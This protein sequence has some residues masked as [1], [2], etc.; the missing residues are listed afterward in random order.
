MASSWL[1]TPSVGLL[2]VA[3]ALAGCA[4]GKDG[5]TGPPGSN[6]INASQVSDDF[7]ATL[8]V[9]SEVTGVTISSPPRVTF[10]LETD[11]GIPITGIVP[12]WDQEH[13]Y[14]RFTL[15]KLV[16]G[17][18]GDP[19]S[20]VSYIRDGTTGE[21]D[22]D[23]GSKLVDHL[24]GSYTFTF[25]TDVTAVPGVSYQSG[26]THRLGGQLGSSSISLEPQN[27]V[28]DFRPQ[29][30]G[31]SRTRNIAVMTSCNECHDNL[32]F[33]GRRFEVEYCVTCHNPDLADGEGD[34]SFMIHRIHAAGDFDV[35]EGGIS[36]AEVTYPQDLENCLKCHN[37]MD[38][39][40]PDAGNW[41]D[42]PNMTACDGCHDVFAT[43]THSGGAQSNNS[44]CTTCHSTASIV[45]AHTTPNATPN[46]P[47]LLPD[48][49]E[50]VY[51]LIDASVGG[52]S[53]VTVNLRILADGAPLNVANLPLSLATPDRYPGLLLAWAQR[54]DGIDEPMD[55]N[56]L[57]QRAAQPLSIGLDDFLAGG[58]AGTHAFDAG[59]GV[60][61][62]VVTDEEL[63]FPLDATLRAV[64]LQGYLQQDISGE[65][66]S[67]HTPSAV[68]AV[69]GDDERRHVVDSAKC[70]N[71]HE[72]F[73]GHG[74]NRTYNIQICTLCHVPNLSSS[75]RTVVDPLLRDLDEDLQA[76]LD[77]GTLDPSV[78]PLDPLTY[79]EDA[80]SLKDLVHG[81]HASGQ[82]D[83]PFQFVRGPNRQGYY[84]WSE[85]TFP[86]GASTSDCQLCHLDGSYDLPLMHGLLATTVRTTGVPDG[87]DPSVP[88]VEDAFVAVPNPTDWINTPTASSCFDCH[89]SLEAMAHMEQ[90]GALLSVPSVPIGTYWSNR[91][92]LGTT[93]ESCSVCHGPGKVA[94][95]DAVHNK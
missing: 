60:N 32:V 15:T 66:V 38:L 39:A 45:E 47:N 94:D 6:V 48:Q 73:E 24:D 3:L 40:T 29:G 72:W 46:N 89:T 49:L 20:W 13:R 74:G 82:R 79:P 80:Q 19:D 52:D 18:D 50:I 16:P 77:A 61:T 53:D 31:V 5:A 83:R 91:S 9:V 56:N 63:Q 30:G 68:A 64:G 69:T 33:H 11:T 12:F 36:Y 78:D 86:R 27:F 84:D 4:D 37:P 76:A 51:E 75:G 41:M 22:Y 58:T 57:G 7:L 59:T 35:L 67:L 43:G 44:M 93:F 25:S 2:A 90:N 42:L 14:V 1:K 92:D 70:S 10:T 55:Y 54:Q 71:C 34:M 65:I 21:P 85:V 28:H 95:L 87:S 26:L 62:F 88:D 17:T 23:T 81:I 8:D